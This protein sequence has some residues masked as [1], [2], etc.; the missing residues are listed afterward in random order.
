MNQN[1][2]ALF[3]GCDKGVDV[4]VHWNVPSFSAPR[5]HL[6]CHLEMPRRR[7]WNLWGSQ[8][9]WLLPANGQS[10]NFVKKKISYLFLKNIIINAGTDYESLSFNLNYNTSKFQILHFC[11]HTRNVSKLK[12][13]YFNK[14]VSS[15]YQ[16]VL[17]FDINASN[18]NKKRKYGTLQW[19]VCFLCISVLFNPYT[20]TSWNSK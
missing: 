4:N 13:K 14:N 1:S 18:N 20:K 19:L 15:I 8:W 5:K 7:I 9:Q 3:N 2:G 10:V 12:K 11:R 6:N 16:I 17:Y